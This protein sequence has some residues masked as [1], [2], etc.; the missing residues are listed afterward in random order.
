M[1]HDELLKR[2]EAGKVYKWREIITIICPTQQ[3]T[4]EYILADKLANGEIVRVKEG[5]KLTI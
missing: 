1:N 5:Y 4:A 3:S 2:T